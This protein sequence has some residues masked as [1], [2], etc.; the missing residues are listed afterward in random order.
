MR[1]YRALLHLYPSSFRATYGP[2]L[3]VMFAHRQRDSSGFSATMLIWLEAVIDIIHNAALMHLELCVQ[4]LRYAVRSL[5]QARGFAF[6]AIL[7][8]A[9]GIGATTT[10]FSITD[11]VLV[12]PLPFRQSDRL[13]RLWQDQA[14]RGYPQMELS[15]SNYVEWKRLAS[16]FEGMSAYTGHSAN[17]VGKG[18]P[19]RIEGTQATS[20]LFNV[21]GTQAALGRALTSVDDLDTAPRVVVLSNRLW[22]TT[23]GGDTGILGSRV[24]LDEVPHVIVGVMPAGFEFPRRDGQYWVPLRFSLE[25]L[26]DRTDTYLNVVARLRGGVSLDQARSEMRVV[27]GQL[28]RAYP[29][30]NARTSA[31][32]HWL[33]NQVSSQAR[34]LLMA[35]VGASIC[36]LLIACTNLANLLL[37][38]ALVRQQELAV[39]AAMGAGWARLIRQ[40][41][42]ESLVLAVLGGT[43]GV[44]LA[45]A[46]TP[47]VSR[48]V[49]NTLPIPD[50][51]SVDMRMLAVAALVT[52]AAGIGFGLIPALRVVRSADPAGLREGA[53]AGAGRATERLRSAL[54]VA[55]ITASVVLLVSSGLLVRALWRV[56]QI[57]PGFRSENVLTL[58]TVLSS[59]AYGNT[60]RRQQFYDRVLG[61]IKA[62]PGVTSAAYISH[63]PMV[64]RGGIWPI[65][66]DFA[67]LGDEA[68]SSW[69]PDP[70][71]T[72]MASFRPTT[73]GFFRATGV[74]LVGG[75]DVSDTDTFDAPWVAVVSQSFADQMWP[76]QDPLGRQFFIAFRER[77]VVGVVGT[78]KVRGLERE[79]EPQVYVPAG[80]VPDNT[81]VFY[82]PKDLVVSASVPTAP[83]VP[84][85]RQIIARADPQQPIS[86]VRMLSEIVEAETAPRRV[87]VRVLAGFAAIAF[88]LAGVGIQGLLAFAV[89]SRTREIGVRMALGAR[90]SEIIGLVLRR[91]VILAALG[92]PIGVALA[93]ATGRA[94]QSVLAGVSPADPQVFGAAVALTL[95]MTIAGCLVPAVRAVQV[96]PVVAIRN[97]E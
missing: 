68:R 91:G 78:I 6:T 34:T 28:E 92:V 86:D 70:T 52:L 62:L 50:V 15:P 59:T 54:V 12:R 80:Q 17:L 83:L 10:A 67:R 81:L 36:M 14:F 96:D 5:T 48:L 53:R 4:D 49:P 73:P 3:C 20:D 69:A 22:R 56:Q 72:R 2:E 64:M 85:I 18:E 13:V 63:L 39:R 26:R 76:G 60:A 24:L 57:D 71:E 55:E 46:A 16:S 1:M 31:A 82:A 42:T 84:A 97:N 11:H 41:V 30:E 19:Q 77:T 74:P 35:L 79:S 9:L 89:S 44:L 88:L 33:R 37:A 38:R 27:A 51:P 47:L 90:S 95:L 32:V 61:E 75:R 8:A 93:A 21:L 66:L 58:R 40:M 43:L 65:I 45:V 25:A 94:L 23:F 29:K 87:Q 7:I